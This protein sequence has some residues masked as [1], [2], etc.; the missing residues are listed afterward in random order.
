MIFDIIL[1]NGFLDSKINNI[2]KRGRKGLRKVF[3]L[4]TIILIITISGEVFA[5]YI[6]NKNFSIYLFT[7]PFYFDASLEQNNIEFIENKASFF[8]TLKNY[9][10]QENF[11]KSNINYEISLEDE[12]FGTIEIEDTNNKIL[13][14][15]NL[16]ANTVKVNLYSSK[17]QGITNTNLKVSAISPYKEEILI[18]LSIKQFATEISVSPSTEI[19]PVGQRKNLTVS[20]KPDITT[21]KSVTWSSSNNSI[22]TVDSSGVVTGLSQ[23][24]AVITATT[25]D[26]T[27]LSATSNI[28]VVQLVNGIT[29]TPTEATILI[30]EKQNYTAIIKPDNATNK[31][32][33]WSSSN[34]SIATVD[35]N[36][37]VTGVKSGTATITATAA[38]GSNIY[39]FA[40]ITVKQKATITNLVVN[41]SF[42]NGFDGW[43]IVGSA[44]S[45]GIA[46]IP[47]HGTYGAYRKASGSQVNYLSQN[48]YWEE[49]HVYYYFASANSVTSQTFMAD[50][51]L[52]GG[53]IYFTTGPSSFYKGSS[54]FVPNFTGNNTISVNFASTTDNINT[55]A[56]GVVDLTAAFGAGNEPSKEWCDA[57]INYFDGSIVVYK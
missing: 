41:G 50:V 54:L 22:A 23:G 44:S 37:V 36:G 16:S 57:N 48:I 2:K 39:G 40:T 47:V 1:K 52:K 53:T 3:C 49:G 6:F 20:V 51:L 42:E 17:S 34:T 18:P 11:S 9:E 15:N 5:K 31:N 7:E 8:V 43:T 21:D 19:V 33:I 32:I 26:G 46:Q 13:T 24:N 27:E 30:G 29:V 45:W 14:G 35:N 38:D 12:S 55:D 56:V 25:N 10:S 28:T 4:I